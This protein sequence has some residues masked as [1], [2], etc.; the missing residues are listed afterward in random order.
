MNAANQGL[1]RSNV[2]ACAASQL[3]SEGGA[4]CA[5]QGA[6][7]SVGAQFRARQTMKPSTKRFIERVNRIAVL[8]V[9]T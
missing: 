4:S 6:A 8:W 9:S 1:Q 3:R 2:A 7:M 5:G